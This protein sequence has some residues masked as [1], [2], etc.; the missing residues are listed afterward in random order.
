MLTPARPLLELQ[1]FTNQD[2][3][4]L[5]GWVQDARLLLQWSGPS[6]TYPLDQLQLK[7]NQWEAELTEPR[8]HHFRAVERSTGA[9]IGHIELVHHRDAPQNGRLAR[10]LIGLPAARGRGLGEEMVRQAVDFGFA[11]LG[12]D[13][14]DLAVYTFNTAAIACYQ[15][16]GFTVRKQLPAATQFSGETWSGQIMA[17]DQAAYLA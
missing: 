5:I 2:F 10:V 7:E 16:I 6:Y 8:R 13:L 17:M 11:D 3:S 9:V 14:V 15:R 4:R 1:R 12:L